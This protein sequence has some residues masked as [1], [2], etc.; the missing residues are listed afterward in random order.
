MPAVYDRFLRGPLFG[1]P[2]RHL[3]QRGAALHPATVLELAAGTGILTRELVAALPG[4]QITAT[5]LNDAMVAYGSQQVPMATWRAADAMHLPFDD[6]SFDL[7]TCQFGVMFFPDKPAAFREMA[8]VLAPGGTALL[9]TWDRVETSDV[10]A[11]I[12]AAM[13]E[14]LPAGA[15]PFL[16]RVPHGYFDR[17]QI[18]ADVAAGGLQC[19][20]IDLV[21]LSG[22]SPSAADVAKGYCGG[23]PLRTFL[24]E[25][26]DSDVLN[27]RV[28]SAMER[29]LGPGPVSGRLTFH[30]ISASH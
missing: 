28:V 29:I 5:D 2:A 3:A 12:G 9:S 18:A 7:V 22:D 4:A 8:R 1:P 20:G 11:A 24:A 23:T 21:E 16:T 14:V 25:A 17:E 10:A 13:D 27:T 19:D 30:V 6:G 26:G 15:P